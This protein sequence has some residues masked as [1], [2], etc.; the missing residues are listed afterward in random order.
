MRAPKN[1][2][3]AR[4]NSTGCLFGTHKRSLTS[5]PLLRRTV[6]YLLGDNQLIL[7]KYEAVGARSESQLCAKAPKRVPVHI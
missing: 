5:D 2:K 3:A 6:N 7:G 1:K 4:T